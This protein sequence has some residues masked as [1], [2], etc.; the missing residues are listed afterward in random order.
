MDRDGQTER[1]KARHGGEGNEGMIEWVMSLFD[2]Y[3]PAQGDEPNSFDV[4]I[5]ANMTPNEVCDKVEELLK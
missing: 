5:A 3:E 4:I 2:K 1:I